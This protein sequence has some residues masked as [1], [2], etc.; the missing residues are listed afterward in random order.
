MSAKSSTGN[1]R[2]MHDDALDYFLAE[3]EKVHGVYNK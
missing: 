3:N 1:Q 2:V